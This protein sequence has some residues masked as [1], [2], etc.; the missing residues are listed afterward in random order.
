LCWQLEF[1]GFVEE[2]V[3]LLECDRLGVY[4][5][6]QGFHL[7][8]EILFFLKMQRSGFTVAEVSEEVKFVSAEGLWHLEDEYIQEEAGSQRYVDAGR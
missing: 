1:G 4:L 5:G 7:I 6:N 2:R 3:F 8:S